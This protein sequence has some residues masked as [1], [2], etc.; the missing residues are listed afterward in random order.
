MKQFKVKVS[1]DDYGYILVIAENEEAA[2]EKIESGEWTDDEYHIKGGGF[3]VD[4]V[5]EI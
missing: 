3:T 2:Q 4:E 1:R 5:E